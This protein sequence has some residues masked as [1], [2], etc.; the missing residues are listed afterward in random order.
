MN[1]P[2]TVYRHGRNCGKSAL[3]SSTVC[4]RC[5]QSVGPQNDY[6]AEMT[7]GLTGVGP[8]V[9]YYHRQCA[10]AAAGIQPARRK[11]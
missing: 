7:A 6:V 9:V 1:E 10:P 3:P 8:T 4:K 11:A 2:V 5:G